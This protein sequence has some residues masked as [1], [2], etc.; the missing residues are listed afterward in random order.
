MSVSAARRALNTLT[1]LQQENLTQQQLDS[2][3]LNPAVSTPWVDMPL[4]DDAGNTT[5]L[6]YAGPPNGELQGGDDTE[7]KSVAIPG[8]RG[9]HLN[10][11]DDYITRE[12]SEIALP[13]TLRIVAQSDGVADSDAMICL[14]NSADAADYVGLGLTETGYIIYR[15]NGSAANTTASLTVPAKHN[16]W[17]LVVVSATACTVYLNG[18]LVTAHTGLTSKAVDDTFDVLTIGAQQAD[19][20]ADYFDGILSGAALWP[21]AFTISDVRRDHR[22]LISREP[23]GQ[24]QYMQPRIG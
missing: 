8:G 6:D 9:L 11:G 4:R 7:D 16:V 10:G 15:S 12:V 18:R 2:M 24:Q 13:L 3:L 23:H 22:R 14:S 17:H 19:T 21:F 5:V 20:P 1:L